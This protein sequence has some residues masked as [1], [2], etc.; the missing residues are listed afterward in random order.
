MIEENNLLSVPKE[1]YGDKYQDHILDIYKLYVQ[2]SENISARRQSANSFFLTLNTA[3]IGAAG[4]IDLETKPFS[5]AIGL[6]GIALCIVWYRSIRAYKG[7]NSGKFK[8]IHQIESKLPISVFNSEWNAVGRGKN[9]KLYLPFTK[10]E[11]WIPFTFAVFHLA[12]VLTNIPW[13]EFCGT[14]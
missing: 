4:Y 12:I 7:L 9:T 3:I 6:A 10:I 2:S 13:A 8:V 1:E 11:V 14:S 5:W